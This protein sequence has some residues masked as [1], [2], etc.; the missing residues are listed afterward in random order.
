MNDEYPGTLLN[1]K[2]LLGIAFLLAILAEVLVLANEVL[3]ATIVVQ[4]L[5]KSVGLQG[6]IRP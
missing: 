4:T 2:A 3:R 5:L 6:K 1:R